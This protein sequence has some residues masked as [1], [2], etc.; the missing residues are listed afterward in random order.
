MPFQSGAGD[1]W[2]AELANL[3]IVSKALQETTPHDPK[4]ARECAGYKHRPFPKEL[5]CVGVST[6]RNERPF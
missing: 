3:L 4:L 6:Q 2:L 1:T 5:S